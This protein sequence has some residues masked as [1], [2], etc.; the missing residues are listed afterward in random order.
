MTRKNLLLSSVGLTVISAV[1]FSFYINIDSKEATYEMSDLSVFNKQN[2]NDAIKWLEARYLDAETGERISPERLSEIYKSQLGGVRSSLVFEELGPDNI[3]GRTRA[4]QPDRIN[5]NVVYAGGVSGGL[6]ISEDRAQTWNRIDEFPGSPYISSMAQSQDGTIFVAT[7]S[8]DESWSGD[9]LY[10]K[11]QT[12]ETWVLVPGTDLAADYAN[13]T[14]VVCA[15][16]SN[17][18]FFTS[19]KG[20]RKWTIGA[21][22]I[23]VVPTG[24]SGGCQALQISRDGT[25]IVVAMGGSRTYVSEDGG[26]TFTAVFG[27]GENQVPTS[28]PRIEFAISPNKNSNNKYTVYASRT[29]NNLLG[30]Y[31]SLDN[32]LSWSRIAGSSGTPSNLDIYRD[33]GTYN[34]ILSVAPNDSKRL[35]IGGIDIWD[36]NQTTSNPVY[37][38]FEQLSNWFLSPANVKYVHADNHEMKWDHT[39]RLYIGNDGGVGVTN[40]Y[41]VNYYPAN[42]GY[43]VTQFYGIAMDRDGRVMGGT[44]DNGTL[45][46][47]FTFN[48]YKNFIEVYG[49]DGF[50]CEISFFNPK[51]LFSTIYFGALSRSGDN[52]YSFS[53]FTPTGITGVNWGTYAQSFHTEFVLAEYYDEN[54]RDFVT[55]FPRKNYN[56]G[57]FIR[58]PSM[59]TGDTIDYTTDTKLYYSD[60]VT[61]DP[62]KTRTDYRITSTTSPNNVIDLGQTAFTMITDVAPAGIS[63][64]D[65]ISVQGNTITIATASPYQHYF[66]TSPHPINPKTLDLFDK[67]EAFEIP[68]DTI[69]VKDPYQS[70]LIIH[71]P[72]GQGEIFATRDALRFAKPPTWIRLATG[73]GGNSWNSIDIEFSK[74]LNHCY[75]SGGS[76]VWRIDGLGSMYEQDY[77]TPAQ[78][79][80][81]VAALGTAKTRITTTNCEGIA[82]NPNNPNDLIILQQFGGSSSNIRR[83]TNATNATPTFNTLR[84]L[85]MPAYDA[86]IDRNNPQII[87]VGTAFGVKVSDNGGDNNDANT[88]KD[89]S[90]GF[91]NV[92][93]YEVRQN[94][95]TWEEGCTRPG[96][97][98]LGTFGRGIWAS[99]SLLGLG[100]NNDSKAVEQ[101]KTNLKV[102]PNPVSDYTK[103]NF[104]LYKNS[105]VTIQIYNISGKLVKTI[106]E[107]NVLKGTQTIEI[108]A[109]D[110]NR[111]SY[112]IKFNAGSISESIKFMKN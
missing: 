100:N 86:I 8:N 15:E 46:N 106:N 37:G 42:R 21:S 38:G 35:L 85:P 48:S 27:S 109:S 13:I 59:A 84:S 17:T 29:D 61:Y 66:A 23:E 9:G 26:T 103:L 34:S 57:D 73:V 87:V 99:S 43:N 53:S 70:W 32:G 44:Q 82:L 91:K 90:A 52:G 49:G 18:I 94:W 97:I 47:P 58:V 20:L 16:N 40:D 39:N 102:Y 63:P 12:S 108:D 1:V 76:G 5:T 88:W 68:W 89:A 69:K 96:E 83:T 14:E 72:Q 80:T 112:I 77:A 11:T 55:Y 2:A 54:S 107:K 71:T 62:A 105:D 25:V 104:T 74:D 45:Y 95:R 64:N 56:V 51:V 78:F 101:L 92:P 41:G 50:E 110:L 75:F 4:I 30:M 6:F 24:G 28:A 93:V 111:G 10:Y 31:A 67:Q 60:V 33:Q 81:A 19:S 22:A 98:Y 79:R 3:G 65:V 36:W 7:G